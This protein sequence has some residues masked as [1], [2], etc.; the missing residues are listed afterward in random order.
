MPAEHYGSFS[1]LDYSEET[2]SFRFNFGAITAVSLP[3]FL[4]QFG[5]LRTALGNITIGTISRER[6]VGDETVLSNIPPSNQWAQREIRWLVEYYAASD[7]S[8][9]WVSSIACPKT[10][11]M[12]HGVKP[13][14]ADLTHPDIAA[15]VTAFENLVVS[16]DQYQEAVI[17]KNI[18]LAGRNA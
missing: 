18:Y 11:L 13:E 1:I 4:T 3:G 14:R 17:V 5:A 2:S 7:D 9:F 16:P 15:F 8:G 10:S 12:L 6:W